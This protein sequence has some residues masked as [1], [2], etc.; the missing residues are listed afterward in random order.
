[1][2]D[3]IDSKYP[4]GTEAEHED[5]VSAGIEFALTVVLSKQQ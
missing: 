4:Y 1:M 2:F 5:A 3:V